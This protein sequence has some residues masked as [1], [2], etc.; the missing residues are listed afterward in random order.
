[1]RDGAPNWTVAGFPELQ[2]G[3]F[4]ALV[5]I[6]FQN[7][8]A[9]ALKFTRPRTPAIIEVG[10]EEQ[11]GVSVVYVRD[12][13]V[14][15]SMKY[16]NKLFGVFQRLHRAE[17]FEGTGVGLATVQRIIQK[18]GGRIWAQAELD[19]AKKQARAL[20]AYSTEGVTGQGFWLAFAE[21]FDSYQWFEDYV[22]RL[23]AVT[24][25]EV[26]DVAKRYLRPQNRTIGWLVPTGGE[27]AE[28][29]EE[30]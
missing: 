7:L 9:N 4:I 8:L 3:C 16:A 15:F 12:N 6:V 21:N 23:S 29:D 28:G 24:L 27:D 25:E 5:K 11:D 26:N 10:R 18:H 2:S 20:F 1:M 19:K 22:S 30:E 17:D 13:G 14:G